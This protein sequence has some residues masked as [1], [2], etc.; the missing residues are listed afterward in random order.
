MGWRM[1]WRRAETNIEQRT[2]WSLLDGG[3]HCT[4][5]LLLQY[6]GLRGLLWEPLPLSWKVPGSAVLGL[7]TYEPRQRL[8]KIFR[9]RN[10]HSAETPVSDLSHVGPIEKQ[11]DEGWKRALAAAQKVRLV[12]KHENWI[13]D[14]KQVCRISGAQVDLVLLQTQVCQCSERPHDASESDQQNVRFTH[15]EGGQG[16][17]NIWKNVFSRQKLSLEE[18]KRHHPR[19]WLVRSADNEDLYGHGQEICV[20]GWRRVWVDDFHVSEYTFISFNS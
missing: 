14:Q 8:R 5:G 11:L 19:R 20:D 2:S 6:K 13:T 10:D 7:P 4:H 3:P 9:L 15:P 18:T 17:R 12:P 16:S 1:H